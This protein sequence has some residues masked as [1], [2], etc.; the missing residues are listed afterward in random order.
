MSCNAASQDI[1]DNFEIV[2]GGI[3]SKYP[4]PRQRPENSLAGCMFCRSFSLDFLFII[5]LKKMT[6]VRP[7]HKFYGIPGDCIQLVTTMGRQNQTKELLQTPVV[8]LGL[9][10]YTEMCYREPCGEI[11]QKWGLIRLG[12]F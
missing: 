10:C 1:L 4:I 12:L 2:L 8:L 6:W 5:C 9:L 11:G 7:F 3:I